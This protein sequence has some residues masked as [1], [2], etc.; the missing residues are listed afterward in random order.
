MGLIA[1]LLLLA[2][3]NNQQ[4]YAAASNG[5]SGTAK[6]TVA[7]DPTGSDRVVSYTGGDYSSSPFL[8]IKSAISSLPT[9]SSFRRLVKI[10]A[11]A[12]AYAGFNLSGFQGGGDVLLSFA[13]SAPSL[14]GLATGTCGGGTTTTQCSVASGNWNS[15]TL[16]QYF[17]TF[18]SSDSDF[19]TIRPIKSKTATTLTFDAVAGLI[20]GT[21]FN[22]VKAA[23]SIAT[24]SAT[25]GGFNVGGV[26]SY[27]GSPVRVL[28]AKPAASLDYGI[29]STGN[30]L[31]DAHGLTL[32][33]A[34]NY[35][36]VYSNGDLY[37]TLDDSYASAGST[38]QQQG[39]TAELQNDVSGGGIFEIDGVN[40]APIQ[41]DAASVTA[42]VPLT[43]RRVNNVVVGFKGASNTA[44]SAALFDSCTGITLQNAGLTGTG[45][46]AYGVQFIN[47]G[48][49]NVSGASITGTSG[50]FSIDGS[51]SGSQ[52]W[53]QLASSK[54]MSRYGAGTLLLGGSTSAEVFIIESV[55]INGS[56]FDVAN[57]Q[58]QHGGR[59]INYG[60]FH[61]A[62]SKLGGGSADGL[63]AHAGGGAAS[64][65]LAGLGQSVFTTVTSDHDSAILNNGVIGGMMQ[66]V[67]N[68]SAKILDVYPPSTGNFNGGVADTP[69]QIAA[70][71]IG[72]FWTR[73]GFVGQNYF[74][75]AVTP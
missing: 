21:T 6:V 19:P 18:A 11:N 54:A 26:F 47:G 74:G 72:I 34:A 32:S 45:N 38:L 36:T 16:R 4:N 41:L 8:T 12:S 48:Q 24:G 29:Y 57:A 70:G 23:T 61:F 55:S 66:V 27:N 52:T 37:S 42:G 75:Y 68:F 65:T 9:Q 51:T 71:K 1:A 2:P 13:T 30:A 10:N 40:S 33:I 69:Y 67:A 20:S 49:Y 53:T 5:S 25:F 17:V 59:V 56:N 31:F 28:F 15:D 35:F 62:V 14:T 64:A 50:D 22:I 63:T 44:A 43:V 39:G 46:S 3:F 7:V 58:E 73:D 60:F